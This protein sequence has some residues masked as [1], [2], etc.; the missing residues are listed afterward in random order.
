MIDA[1]TR[2]HYG[3]PYLDAVIRSTEGF[4][5]RHWVVYAEQHNFPGAPTMPCPDTRDQLYEIARI[6]GGDRLR[7]LDHPAPGVDVV[8]REHAEID[9]MLEL[10]SDEVLHQDLAA[11]IR[12]AFLEGHLIH[13]RYRLPMVHHWRSFRYACSDAQWPIRL[14]LPYAEADDVVF[15]DRTN[16]GRYIHHFG[17]VQPRAYMDYKWMLSIHKD[18]L[19]PEW[20]AEIYDCFPERLTDLHPVSNNGFWN[21]EQFPDGDLPAA[22]IN[23]PYR[24]QEVI[25]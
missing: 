4:A 8:L 3:A 25:E 23:H 7:W 19:R 16:P 12:K 15:Y 11:H 10:D 18:E 13:R 20:F 24:Y 1:L 9:L 5:E 14:Y 6:A 22:L 2:L 17:Y 21:A